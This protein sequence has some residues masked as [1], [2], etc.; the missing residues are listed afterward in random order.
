MRCQFEQFLTAT[1]IPFGNFIKGP[2]KRKEFKRRPTHVE[3][4]LRTMRITRRK[5]DN[6]YRIEQDDR[7]VM[8]HSSLHIYCTKSIVLNWT[9]YLSVQLNLTFHKSLTRFRLNYVWCRS[10]LEIE[11]GI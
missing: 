6:S 11:H 5:K 7:R 10:K 1:A 8:K 2:G 4:N 9:A 3:G